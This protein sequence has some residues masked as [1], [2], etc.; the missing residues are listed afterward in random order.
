MPSGV[1]VADLLP[2]CLRRAGVVA[3]GE[4]PSGDELIDSLFVLNDM[5]EAWSTES[6]SVWRAAN[7]TFTFVPGLAAH[8]IGPAG[9]LNVS[10]RPVSI[11]GGFCTFNGVDFEFDEMD[12]S[13]YNGIPLKTLSQPI[14]E[15]F[16]YV[17]DSPLG[18]ITFFPVPSQALP[19]QLSLPKMLTFPVAVSDTL[20][21]PPG[22]VK[23][24]RL[25]LALEL[26]GEFAVEP[27]RL[28]APL[29]GDAKG[30]FKRSNIRNETSSMDAALLSPQFALWQRGY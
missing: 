23:A 21:G 19:F 9:N 5:L 7:Q 13:T 4:T 2:L 25:C 3:S 26:C 29:A 22:F 20:A 14:V 8:T 15:R 30:D 16:L 6:L 17:N 28:L 1:A 24:I 18:T 11:L 12:Q 27:D 10:V